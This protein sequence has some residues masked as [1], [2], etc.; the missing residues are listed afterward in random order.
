MPRCMG[1]A[2]RDVEPPPQYYP[3]IAGSIC[4]S[5][6]SMAE[7]EKMSYPPRTIVLGD[8]HV[9]KETPEEVTSDL[10]RLVEA[11]PGARIIFAGDL[12]DL[13]ASLPRRPRAEAVAV[14]LAAHPKAR[15]ALGRHVDQG[16]E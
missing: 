10:A 12:F 15:A 13:A 11:H 9:V 5:D 2:V 16:G 6:P 1:P 7:T 4:K 14:A 3:P 8:L